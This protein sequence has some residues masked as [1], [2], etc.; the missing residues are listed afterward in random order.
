MPSKHVSRRLADIVDYSE[1]ITRYVAG[2][3]QDSFLADD[4]A[5]DAV[6]RCLQ[7]ISEA[8]KKLGDDAERLMPE[9]PWKGIRGIGNPLRHEY[10]SIEGHLIW[11]AVC[12]CPSLTGACQIAL[13]KLQNE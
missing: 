1:R 12:G 13:Q 10:D 8:A 2:R 11:E 7:C 5:R 3:D 4:M 9:Q 6:L